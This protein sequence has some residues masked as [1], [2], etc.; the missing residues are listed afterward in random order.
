MKSRCFRG[1][2][3]SVALHYVLVNWCRQFHFTS[4]SGRC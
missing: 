4:G 3:P 2:C 1:T